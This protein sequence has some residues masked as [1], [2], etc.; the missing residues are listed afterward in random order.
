MSDANVPAAATRPT[1]TCTSTRRSRWPITATPAPSRV[2]P[3]SFLNA[4]ALARSPPAARITASASGQASSAAR[5]ASACPAR[6]ASHTTTPS[7]TH[8]WKSKSMHDL[9]YL[10]TSHP[11]PINHPL[12]KNPSSVTL[13]H[14]PRLPTQSSVKAAFIYIITIVHFHG[15]WMGLPV[16]SL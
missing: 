14:L 5:S 10:L 15:C 9:L 11:S 3:P 1:T 12:I 7:S 4:G 13:L 8:A 16:C 6:T 2:S